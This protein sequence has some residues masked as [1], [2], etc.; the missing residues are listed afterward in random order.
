[1]QLERLLLSEVV[2]VCTRKGEKV[3]HIGIVIIIVNIITTISIVIVS[4]SSILEGGP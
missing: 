3:A 4:L 2:E 1:M